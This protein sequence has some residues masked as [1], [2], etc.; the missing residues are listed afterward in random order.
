DDELTQ[1]VRL[2]IAAAEYNPADV[3]IQF[4]F[5]G[6]HEAK[7]EVAQGLLVD[8]REDPVG[9]ESR[10]AVLGEDV[11]VMVGGVE[12]QALA[13]SPLA[14]LSEAGEVDRIE[15]AHLNRFLVAL[16]KLTDLN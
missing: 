6:P 1:L 13:T 2:A 16:R 8:R 15:L 7:H 11:D 4:R 9:A 5:S 3:A 10:L 12:T 14:V